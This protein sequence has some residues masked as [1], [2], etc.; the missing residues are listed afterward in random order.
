MVLI[1]SS[2]CMKFGSSRMTL[3]GLTSEVELTDYF[4]ILVRSPEQSPVIGHD[5]LVDFLY[6]SQSHTT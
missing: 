3:G 4:G 5:L 6:C 2:N 1:T